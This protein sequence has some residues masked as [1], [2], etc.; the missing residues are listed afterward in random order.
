MGYLLQAPFHL[1][2]E[3]QQAIKDS[4]ES[5]VDKENKFVERIR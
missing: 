3:Q 2:L 1:V 4:E 5:E